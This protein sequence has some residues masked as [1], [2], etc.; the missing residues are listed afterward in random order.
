MSRH[1]ALSFER[2][3][4]RARRFAGHFLCWQS[5]GFARLVWFSID[6]DGAEELVTTTITHRMVTV[7]KKARTLAATVARSAPITKAT[8]LKPPEFSSYRDLRSVMSEF[9]L[10]VP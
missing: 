8:E 3:K 4:H 6:C 1:C 5:P 9:C 2:Q 7:W 10:I